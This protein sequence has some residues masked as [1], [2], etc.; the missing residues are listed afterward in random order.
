MTYRPYIPTPSSRALVV[1]SPAP[2]R[3]ARPLAVIPPLPFEKRPRNVFARWLSIVTIP[4]FFASAG[5]LANDPDVRRIAHYQFTLLTSAGVSSLEPSPDGGDL[6]IGPI[7]QHALYLFEKGVK[8]PRAD[9]YFASMN[10][11]AVHKQPVPSSELRVVSANDLVRRTAK[12]GSL[13]LASGATFD[14][15]GAA[16]PENAGM[17][18]SASFY[19]MAPPVND[20]LF[21]T[22]SP[23][24][25]K[26]GDD[27]TG[28]EKL[29][30]NASLSPEQPQTIFGGLTEEE[31]REREIRC[32]ATAIY[33]EARG[34]PYRGQVAVG[35]V[36]MN[37]IRSPIYPKT[38]CGV[39]YQGH[40]N[41][42]ACQFSFACDGKP[43]R[44]TNRAQWAAS[45]KVAKQVISREVWIDEVGYA[46]HYHAN[47]VS[48]DWRNLYEKVTQI[49]VHIFYRP[50]PGATQVAL[51]VD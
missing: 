49:G 16:R 22:F 42:N 9:R 5:F 29:I 43:D 27:A 13:I 48:P 35:Q 24:G 11:T 7:P 1:R 12:S 2:Q 41:R 36:V 46:T 18:A 45:L 6:E 3:V 15:T 10:R 40:L 44:P 20:G 51:A 34:E 32:M 14:T 47:Y 33:F 25:G 38:I 26:S 4:A 8:G 31:F 17:L 50:P 19:L 28:W 39:I 30:R 21:N 37:R 23:G